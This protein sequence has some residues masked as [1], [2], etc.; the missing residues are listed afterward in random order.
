MS[1]LPHLKITYKPSLNPVKIK[2]YH[3]SIGAVNA[4]IDEDTEMKYI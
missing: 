3:N 1:L 2:D 4:I